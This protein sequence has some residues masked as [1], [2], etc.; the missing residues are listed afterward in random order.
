MHIT[1]TD[2]PAAGC[3]AVHDD[4][5]PVLAVLVADGRAVIVSPEA[6]GAALYRRD[7]AAA[8]GRAAYSLAVDG[9][10]GGWRET[11][12]GGADEDVQF[13]RPRP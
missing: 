1:F 10:T 13:E 7:V 2:G 12:Y 6:L 4:A 9:L 5:P 3:D 8:P 11:S